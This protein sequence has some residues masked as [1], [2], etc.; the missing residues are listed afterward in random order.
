MALVITESELEEILR[1][2]LPGEEV[3]AVGLFQPWG[4]EMASGLG[5]GAGF[6]VGGAL[7]SAATGYAAHRGM[8]VADH[9]PPW[10][11]MAVT[12]THVYAFDCSD[13]AGL[14]ATK[15]FT[16]PPYA[17]WERDKIAVH[18][19]RHVTQ[20]TF[21]I[22]D[23]EQHVTWEYTGNLVYKSGGKLIARLFA[24]QPTS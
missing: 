23:V 18:V 8:A 11:A 19:S 2:L 21:A 5:A 3:L 7:V 14:T 10:T 17:S 15:H 24:D 16:G 13:A 9:Q 4:S 20:F 12:P 6:G 1:G 22:D